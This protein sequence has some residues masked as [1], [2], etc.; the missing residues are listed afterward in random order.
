[1]QT[2]TTM[3]DD[4][5]MVD[6]ISKSI[7]KDMETAYNHMKRHTT[8]QGEILEADRDCEYCKIY[9]VEER[10]LNKKPQ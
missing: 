4:M 8:P 7:K 10:I 3:S 6:I 1:M 9:F 5:T 2:K